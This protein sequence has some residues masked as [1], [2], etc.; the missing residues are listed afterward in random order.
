MTIALLAS[1]DCVEAA[2]VR[3][4]V[5][6]STAN[7][8]GQLYIPPEAVPHD[9]QRPLIVFLHGAG[10][11]G[12]DNAAQINGNVDNLFE[13]AREQGMYLYA[14]QA[15]SYGWNSNRTTNA[16]LMVD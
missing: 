9:T 13:M 4:F 15:A 12:V 5:D 3:D 14:P 6:F 7:L 10:E 8:P 16:M 11:S 1:L 2:S